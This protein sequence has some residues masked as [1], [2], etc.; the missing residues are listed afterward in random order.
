M[1]DGERRDEDDRAG[2]TRRGL[3]LL[4]A[5][6]AVLVLGEML[7]PRSWSRWSLPEHLPAWL[8]P[9][10]YIVGAALLAWAAA[11]AVRDWRRK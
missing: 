9:V 8:R 1:A 6:V 4:G 3:A 5:G 2:A 10:S 11:S 7:L